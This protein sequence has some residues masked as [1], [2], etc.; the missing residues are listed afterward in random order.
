MIDAS[1][2]PYEE[3]VATTAEVVRASHA[4]GVSVEAEIGHIF[5]S[6]TGSAERPAKIETKDSFADI[7]DRIC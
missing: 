1:A 7:N 3:N 2:R 4:V 6:V 5:T